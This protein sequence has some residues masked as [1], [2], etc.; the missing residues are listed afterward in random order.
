ML[1]GCEDWTF[2]EEIEGRGWTGARP[3]SGPD[4]AEQ[5][6]CLLNLHEKHDGIR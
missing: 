3:I 2:T 1:D 6:G 4:A 5:K